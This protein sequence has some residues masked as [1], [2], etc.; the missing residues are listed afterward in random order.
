MVHDWWVTLS[1][2][3]GL[4]VNIIFQ[5]LSHR[6]I[7]SLALLQSVFLGFGLGYCL[8]IAWEIQRY[9]Q[10]FYYQLG[11]FWSIL[12]V[13]GVTYTFLGYCYFSIIGLGETARRI[14][15]LKDL[16][17]ARPGGLSIDEILARYSAKDMVDKRLDRLTHNGQVKLV[18][19]RYFINKPL[20]LFCAKF[21]VFMKLAVLGKRS[22]FD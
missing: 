5:I 22:E 8:V 6:L 10:E 1:P 19:G 11:D 18:D 17:T 21:A 16:N 9:S 12:I 2:V 3:F 14:R 4:T 20:M 7:L 15:L 13:N